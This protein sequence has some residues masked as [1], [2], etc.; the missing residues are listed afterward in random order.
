MSVTMRIIQEYDVAHAGEFMA[1]E[2]QFAALEADRPDYPKGRRMKPVSAG[3]PCNCLVW[4]CEFPDI[5]TARRALDMFE[6]DAA[7]EALFVKQAPFFK[8]VRIEFYDNLDF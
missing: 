4:E 2:K 8:Q 6:G 1:L 3:L 7:H 5:Q